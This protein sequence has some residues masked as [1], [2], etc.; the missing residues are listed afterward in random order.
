MPS[1]AQIS[2]III[3]FMTGFALHYCNRMTESKETLNFVALF[4][5][6]WEGS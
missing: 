4:A 3:Q 1:G 5:T 2:V 6:D